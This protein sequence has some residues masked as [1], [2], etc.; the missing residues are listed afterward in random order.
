MLIDLS[1]AY[2]LSNVTMIQSSIF[3]TIICCSKKGCIGMWELFKVLR[4]EVMLGFD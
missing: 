4:E 3:S 2:L 1:C